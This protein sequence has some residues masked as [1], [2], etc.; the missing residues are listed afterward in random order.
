LYAPEQIE[1]TYER[2]WELA[3]QTLATGHPTILDATFLDKQRRERLAA[4]AQAAGTPLVLIETVSKE[5][6]A[7]ERLIV[8]TR[9][10]DSPSDAT[11]EIYQRQRTAVR[12]S[13]PAIP[14]GAIHILVDTDMDRPIHLE[15]VLTALHREAIIAARIPGT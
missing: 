11:V 15:P 6:T 8:R 7:L 10:G 5:E 13:P 12:A 4:V 1:A 9:R 3:T 14:Q 2:L